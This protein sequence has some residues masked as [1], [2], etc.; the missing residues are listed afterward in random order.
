M[1]C[2]QAEDVDERCVSWADDARGAEVMYDRICFGPIKGRR[3][4]ARKRKSKPC[5]VDDIMRHINIPNNIREVLAHDLCEGFLDACE[6]ELASH[7]T[8]NTWDYVYRTADM[9]V[10]GSTWS[11]DI[12]RDMAKRILRLKARL[13]AQGFTQ[14]KGKDYFQKHSHTVPADVFRLFILVCA[15]A[16]LCVTEAD[17]TTAYLNAG[18]DADVFLSQPPGFFLVDEDG[19]ELRG[20]NGEEIVCKVN[21][22]IYGLMQSGMLWELEHH[23]TLKQFGWEQCTAEPCL[24]RKDF[25]GVTCFLCTYVDNL[26]MGF[27][28]SSPHREA[29][30]ARLNTKYKITDLG[31]VS[32]SLGVRLIQNPRIKLTVMNQR[33]MIDEIV[34]THKDQIVELRRGVRSM[35][36]D[37]SVLEIVKSDPESAGAIHWGKMCLVLGGKLNYIATYTRPDICATLSFIMRNVSGA[38][39]ALYNALIKLVRYLRDSADKS[40]YFGANRDMPIRANFLAGA[41]AL[42]ID[43]WGPSDVIFVSDASQG[44]PRPMQCALGFVDGCCV[45][46]RIGRLNSTTLSACEA[47]WFA[48]TTASMLLQAFDSIFS[49]LLVQF[50]KPVIFFCDNQ[51]AVQISEK[52]GTTKHMKHVLTRMA[53]LQEQISSGELVLVHLDTKHNVADIG[54]KVQSPVDFYRLRDLILT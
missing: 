29:E 38:S 44:G 24:F 40:L 15:R 18:V 22:A 5:L 25:D 21:K 2:H 35:P 20:P 4:K 46:W 33:P 19:N 42:A 11:F 48:Q 32:Y 49:F 6:V 7:D 10:C 47:E 17:Y 9:N 8:N 3:V 30:I 39:E 51:A 54:T 31:T 23:G 14:V 53:Y 45:L 16:G 52:D 27:P 36:C 41:H 28:V 50:R 1:D 43:P 37:E 26:F 34:N 13:C 12:K